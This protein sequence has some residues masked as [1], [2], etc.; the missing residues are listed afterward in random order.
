M[1][2]CWSI[3]GNEESL[4]DILYTLPPIPSILIHSHP[5]YLDKEKTPT[6]KLPSLFFPDSP[7]N[8]FQWGRAVYTYYVY[9]FII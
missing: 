1:V 7:T 4:K 3:S 9:G 2:Y 8:T 5:A 6:P